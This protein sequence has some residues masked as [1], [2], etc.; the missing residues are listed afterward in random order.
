[1]YWNVRPTLRNFKTRFER[2][3]DLKLKFL[4]RC[5][6]RTVKTLC[7]PSFEWFCHFLD[8]ASEAVMLI[9]LLGAEMWSFEVQKFGNF[10]HL[11]TFGF[12]FIN[13]FGRSDTHGNLEKTI[14]QKNSFFEGCNGFMMPK[15]HSWGVWN[16]FEKNLIFFHF[17]I[18]PWEFS[19]QFLKSFG[20]TWSQ[21]GLI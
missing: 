7:K 4:F 8:R 6:K 21:N 12:F 11:S 16:I 5:V 3:G 13:F 20:R 19:V 2:E 14:F 18:T 10:A 1:M 17:S 9:G 15:M